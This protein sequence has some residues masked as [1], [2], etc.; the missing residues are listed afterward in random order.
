MQNQ[1]KL[2]F[3]FFP[4]KATVE[5]TDAY[6]KMVYEAFPEC[7]TLLSALQIN[8]NAP[9][10]DVKNKPYITYITDS[11]LMQD[12]MARGYILLAAARTFELDYLFFNSG[13][14]RYSAETFIQ[15]VKQSI[16]MCPVKALVIGEP[17][18][19]RPESD[20][21]QTIDKQAVRWRLITD[22]FIN[23]VICRALDKQISNVNAG[24]FRVRTSK[25][26][27]KEL[28]CVPHY[29]DNTLLCPQLLWHLHYQF[30]SEN[31]Q[32]KNINLAQLGF[33]LEKAV[34]ETVFIFILAADTGKHKKIE[35]L[36]TDFLAP[37]GPCSR[38]IC[39]SDKDWFWDIFIPM[40]TKAYKV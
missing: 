40:V 5:Q 34:K 10:I 29:E 14:L 8:D 30:G 39:Q 13:M 32:I 23:Y 35:E 16:E 26:V 3:A 20:G 28:M 12:L 2:G 9:E 21:L 7:I 1:F 4:R 15:F 22:S 6:I 27:L 18:I 25:D 33:N 19:L 17:P 37:G 36:A 24:V 11:K 31:L 38:W